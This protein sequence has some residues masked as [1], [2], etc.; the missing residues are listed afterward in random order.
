MIEISQIMAELRILAENIGEE[1]E[2][3]QTTLYVAIQLLGE[4]RQKLLK[5]QNNESNRD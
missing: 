3:T 5:E 2:H 4:Y 1:K